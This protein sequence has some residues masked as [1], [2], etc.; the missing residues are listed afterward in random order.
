MTGRPCE[1]SPFF[2]LWT[3]YG[4]S[5]K[6]IM[7]Y[8]NLLGVPF[9]GWL[10]I[11]EILWEVHFWVLFVDSGPQR[12]FLFLTVIYLAVLLILTALYGWF[13]IL[14]AIERE[15]PPVWWHFVMLIGWSWLLVPM[16]IWLVPALGL[17][18]LNMKVLQD[19]FDKRV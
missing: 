1:P 10:A 6:I 12:D 3:T 8:L 2:I 4:R 11:K 7:P 17:L 19:S 18:G 13:L 9:L 5:M 16:F 14:H 15:R